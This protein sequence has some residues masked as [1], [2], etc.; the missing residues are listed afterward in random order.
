M[1]H[2]LFKLSVSIVCTLYTSNWDGA[3]QYGVPIPQETNDAFN[4]E[5]WMRTEEIFLEFS[6]SRGGSC[7]FPLVK[8]GMI[9]SAEH[10]VAKSSTKVKPLSAKI[11]SPGIWNIGEMN[12]DSLTR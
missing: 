6:T 4:M 8:A 11:L 9:S 7:F 2:N 5:L 12:P 3:F 1:L 10:N